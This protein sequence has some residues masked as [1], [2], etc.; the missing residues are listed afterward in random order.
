VFHFANGFEQFPPNDLIRLTVD[1]GSREQLVATVSR[2]FLRGAVR[3][4]GDPQG[5]RGR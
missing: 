5:G 2:L 3:Q 1:G 4:G